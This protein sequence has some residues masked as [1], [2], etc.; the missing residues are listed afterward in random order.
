MTTTDKADKVLE[1]IV[2]V[3]LVILSLKSSLVTG[4]IFFTK[5]EIERKIEWRTK[6]K[7]RLF[8]YYKYV[9]R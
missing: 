7:Q 1:M 5:E 4:S 3:E 2:N 8:S 6:M 9:L